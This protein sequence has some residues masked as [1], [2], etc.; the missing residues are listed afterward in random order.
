MRDEHVGQVHLALQPV[1]KAQDALGDQLIECGSHLVAD[2]E[3]GLGRQCAGD[4]DALFL[5]S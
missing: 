3:F 4:A 2:D 5:P 1:Q